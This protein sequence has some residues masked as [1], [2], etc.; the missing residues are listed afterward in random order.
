MLDKFYCF[1]A[2]NLPKD[3]VKWCFVRVATYNTG[4]DIM[5]EITCF[6]ALERWK[7]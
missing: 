4:S 7:M 6:K 3:L 5:S 2:Y 1:I